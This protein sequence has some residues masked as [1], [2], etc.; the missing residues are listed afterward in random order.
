MKNFIMKFYSSNM[1]LYWKNNDFSD[2]AHSLE[3]LKSKN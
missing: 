3:V 2:V 1:H